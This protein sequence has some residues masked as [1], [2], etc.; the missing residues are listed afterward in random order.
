MF[1]KTECQLPRFL[2][3]NVSYVLSLASV[4]VLSNMNLRVRLRV[5]LRC[6]ISNMWVMAWQRLLPAQ[7][8]EIIMLP[9]LITV[10]CRSLMSILLQCVKILRFVVVMSL[11]L[12]HHFLF[13]R[14]WSLNYVLNC[15]NW[16]S[17]LRFRVVN[18][19]VVFLN[20]SG[21]FCLGLGIFFLC[22]MLFNVSVVSDWWSRSTAGGIRRD[23]MGWLFV[24]IL[25]LQLMMIVLIVIRGTNSVISRLFVN[26]DWN[27][28]DMFMLM[29]HVKWC[30]IVNSRW[31]SGMGGLLVWT[32]VMI[33]V[34]GM[35]VMLGFWC[36]WTRRWALIV[37]ALTVNWIHVNWTIDGNW[38][39]NLLKINIWINLTVN[40][41][42]LMHEFYE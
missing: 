2:F 39:W 41:I 35:R 4:L 38:I 17:L 10:R 12:W 40:F 29:V 19:M 22:G 34:G 33:L 16:M 18:M 11:I 6:S 26:W 9:H 30:S 14:S 15:L 31:W 23:L 5:G 3:V 32:S 25:C 13:L 37:I 7:V 27:I 8:V 42:V 28:L 1:H 20:A 24:R 21:D 36:S